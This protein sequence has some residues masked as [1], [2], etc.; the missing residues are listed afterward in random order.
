ME[1]INFNLLQFIIV[2]KQKTQVMK[3]QIFKQKRY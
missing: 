1:N 3:N 2:M